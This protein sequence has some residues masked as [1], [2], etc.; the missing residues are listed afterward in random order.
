MDLFAVFTFIILI[1][2]LVS[3]INE[4]TFKIPGEIAILIVSVVIFLIFKIDTF[5]FKFPFLINIESYLKSFNIE[6][7]LLDGALCFML[8]AGASKVRFNLNFS[9]FI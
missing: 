3:V 4:R 6:S 9:T 2:T 8:F 1:V 7:Y 5:L